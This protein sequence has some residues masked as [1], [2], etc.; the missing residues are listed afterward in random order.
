[1]L[2]KQDVERIENDKKVIDLPKIDYKFSEDKNIHL[3][4][5]HVDETY[6]SHEYESPQLEN[7]TKV[8]VNFKVNSSNL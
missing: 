6:T 1:M 8:K 4:K 3:I 2:V 7:V 5:D